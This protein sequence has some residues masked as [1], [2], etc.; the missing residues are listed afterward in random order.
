M[1]NGTLFWAELWYEVDVLCSR[2]PYKFEAYSSAAY[3]DELPIFFD[4][5]RLNY[6]ENTLKGRSP[7]EVACICLREGNTTEKRWTWKELTDAVRQLQSALRRFG[8]K[9]GDRVAALTANTINPVIIMLATTSLGAVFT[10]T[11]PDMG[12]SVSFLL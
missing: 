1:D 7:D 3:M 10:S 8:V 2:Y 9:A 4:G 12:A 6:A 11:A 5:A